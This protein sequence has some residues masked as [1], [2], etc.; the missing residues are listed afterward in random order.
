MQEMHRQRQRIAAAQ[1]HQQR[2]NMMKTMN[3]P[4]HVLNLQ[5][6]KKLK[7]NLNQKEA[8]QSV[9]KP[10]NGDFDGIS[11]IVAATT[12]TETTTT[13]STTPD[14]F[15]L[16][17]P[18]VNFINTP[19]PPN[20]LVPAFPTNGLYGLSA[21]CSPPKLNTHGFYK[22]TIEHTPTIQTTTQQA[23]PFNASL[24]SPPPPVSNNDDGVNRTIST[25]L[26]QTWACP[27]WSSNEQLNALLNYEKMSHSHS[28]HNSNNSNNETKDDNTTKT[29]NNNSNSDN[30]NNESGGETDSCDSSHGENDSSSDNDSKDVEMGSKKSGSRKVCALCVHF[31]SCVCV[32]CNMYF[33]FGT[34]IIEKN[35]KC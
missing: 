9:I 4:L 3:P 22:R 10:Y 8:Y 7:P 24:Q 15:S 2:K 25:P 28:T 27:S 17:E 6:N 12:S 16:N 11:A 19:T 5:A 31:V 26:T 13:S 14:T 33:F 21:S 1:Q 18:G 32:L 34:V 29:T 35:Q 20:T 23:P 30:D